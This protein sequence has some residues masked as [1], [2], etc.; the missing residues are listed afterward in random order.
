MTG[1]F[2]GLAGQGRFVGRNVTARPP[3]GLLRSHHR[4]QQAPGRPDRVGPCLAAQFHALILGQHGLRAINR[5]V[6]LILLRPHLEDEFMGKFF[7]LGAKE[8]KVEQPDLLVLELEESL[9]TSVFAPQVL[10]NLACRRG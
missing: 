8:A 2:F 10:E 9:Q 7:A 6:W 5:M 4:T 1:F 3:L